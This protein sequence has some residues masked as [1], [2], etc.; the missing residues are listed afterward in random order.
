MMIK[1]GI[2]LDKN[3]ALIIKVDDDE[4]YLLATIQSNIDHYNIKGG[5][6]TKFKGG[7]QDVVQDSKFLERENHQFKMFFREIVYKVMVQDSLGKFI[8]L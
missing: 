2:W 1:K 6:G 3:K 4:S 8:S 5:S 7:P